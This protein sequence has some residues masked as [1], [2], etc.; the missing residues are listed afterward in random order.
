VGHAQDYDEARR[1]LPLLARFIRA[2]LGTLDLTSTTVVL[3]SDHGNIE[4]LSA[5]N[6]TLNAVPTI[7]WG[8]HRGDIAGRVL[9]L[10]DVTPAIVDTLSLPGAH[11]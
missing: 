1:L 2:L 10:A 3:T 9:T 11:A 4:D 5:R 7:I 8:R 6:H